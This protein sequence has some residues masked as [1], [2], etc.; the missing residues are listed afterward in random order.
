[1]TLEA[2]IERL[3]SVNAHLPVREVFRALAKLH[4]GVRHVYLPS[5]ILAELPRADQSAVQRT[6]ALFAS[7][8][9]A[10]VEERW[11]FIDDDDMDYAITAVD[12]Q[13]AVDSGRFEHPDGSGVEV[14]DFE[15]H[16]ALRY[17]SR[18]RLDQDLRARSAHGR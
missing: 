12:V 17:V 11:T 1:M 6:L 15:K 7:E 8:P 2:H 5:E 3:A 18:D 14:P 16:I 13:E 10:L 9:L 4:E